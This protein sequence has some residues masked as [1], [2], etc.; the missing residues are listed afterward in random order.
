MSRMFHI[1]D[2]LTITT[3]RLVA[4]R[5]IAAVYDILDYMT[6]DK[7][8]THQLGRACAECKPSLLHQHPQLEKET[9]DNLSISNWA[10]W[11]REAVAIYGEQLPVVPLPPGEHKFIDPVEEMR[12][13]VGPDKIIVVKP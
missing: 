1:G 3:G 12:G 8:F 2:I 7:L 9:G 6:G 4:P 13:M 11:L 5:G 10:V